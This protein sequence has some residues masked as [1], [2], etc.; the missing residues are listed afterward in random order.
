[1]HEENGAALPRWSRLD[2][3]M[4]EN[5]R[6][7][8]LAMSNGPMGVSISLIAQ[9]AAGWDLGIDFAAPSSI[10]CLSSE[11]VKTGRYPRFP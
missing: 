10:R 5:Q 4:N 6:S 3:E 9:Y 11:G 1:L 7:P 2:L 8:S